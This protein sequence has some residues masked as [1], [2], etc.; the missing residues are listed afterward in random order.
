MKIQCKN[1]IVLNSNFNFYLFVFVLLEIGSFQKIHSQ[2]CPPNIDFENGNF[3]NWKCFTGYVERGP[4]STNVISLTQSNV[5]IQNRHTLFSS[6]TSS[7]LKDYYGGFPVLCPNGS[8][9]SVKLGNTEGGAEAEGISYEFTIPSNRNNYALVY[10][11]AVVFQDP[12][13][14]SFEQP[15]LELEITNVTDSSEISCSSFIFIPNGSSLPGFFQSSRSDSTAV[16]CKDWSPVTVNLNGLAG[17]KIRLFFKT[18]DCIFTRHFGYAYVDINTECSSEFEGAVF[19]KDDTAVNLIAPYGYQNYT[20]YNSS[21]TQILGQQQAIRFSPPPTIGFNIAVQITPYNGYGC[22]D[23]LYT[24]LYDTLKL[25][26]NAGK[27]LASCN[28]AEIQMGENPKAGIIYS[29]LP[30][31]GLSDAAIA[32]PRLVPDSTREYFL[33]IKNS[34]GGCV[35]SDTVKVVASVIDSTLLLNGKSLYCITSND[36]AVLN[37]QLNDSIQW[38]KDNFPLIGANDSKLKITESGTYFAKLFTKY[39]CETTTKNQTITIETPIKGIL[40]PLKYAV[41]N[42][43]LELEARLFGER[44]LW[45]PFINLNNP[46]STKPL[47]TSSIEQDY[48]YKIEITS[49]AGCL[50]IDT[51]QVKVIKEIKIYVPSAF[52]PNG[53]GLNDFLK[54]SMF[55]IKEFYFFRVFN[56]LGQLVYNMQNNQQGWNGIINNKPQPTGAYVWVVQCLGLDNKIYTEKGTTVLIR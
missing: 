13:H 12:N 55:G 43:P 27:D 3:T 11:Y 18:A 19:C 7:N 10:N 56:R 9:Y 37:V 15:R 5:S 46:N 40:Y 20:W 38:Y 28:G 4:N 51:Q 35:N 44:L 54:P 8:K 2:D 16:W 39:G 6:S 48:L 1:F 29:W 36:S 26:A 31:I 49:N 42:L 53:N 32:N 30:T 41:K 47:F 17:K 24:K 33:T 23:T 25:K 45:N 34:G 50:T 21:F 22:L 14:R 52:T